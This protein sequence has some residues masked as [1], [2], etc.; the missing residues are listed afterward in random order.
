MQLVNNKVQH[1]NWIKETNRKLFNKLLLSYVNL[2]YGLF[3]VCGLQPRCLLLYLSLSITN[4]HNYP[5]NVKD[6]DGLHFRL[7]WQAKVTVIIIILLGH[8][9]TDT[10]QRQLH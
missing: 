6:C 7:N 10:L 4:Y 2:Y 3:A 8:F 9:L 5:A 1:K